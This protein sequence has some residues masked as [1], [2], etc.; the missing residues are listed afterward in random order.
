MEVTCHWLQQEMVVP[1]SPQFS[2][3]SRPPFQHQLEIHFGRILVARNELSSHFC[4]TLA[5]LCKH[6]GPHQFNKSSSIDISEPVKWLK[7]SVSLEVSCLRGFPILVLR[8]WMMRKRNNKGRLP[9]GGFT[10]EPLHQFLV[11]FLSTTFF[12]VNK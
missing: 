5:D 2:K 3:R 10:A 12:L 1:L 4:K 8:I 7:N 11:H 6:P 9:K